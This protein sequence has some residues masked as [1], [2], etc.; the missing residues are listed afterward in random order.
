MQGRVSNCAA[1]LASGMDAPKDL[2]YPESLVNQDYY[3]N[4]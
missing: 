1:I 2:T 3:N 4:I